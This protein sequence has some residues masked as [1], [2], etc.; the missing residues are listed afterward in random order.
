MEVP[1]G[2]HDYLIGDLNAFDAFDVSRWMS[3]ILMFLGS[4]KK[5]DDNA[6]AAV[7]AFTRA[8]TAMAAQI[9]QLDIHTSEKLCLAAVRRKEAGGVG[10]APIIAAGS[11]V[12]PRM[13]YD[14]IKMPEML[15]LFWHVM[16]HNKL[17][18]FF[19]PPQST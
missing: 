17:P 15:A 13:M 16:A 7:D 8:M 14:D 18:D 19:A 10:W 1:V 5:T 12:P 9:P 4:V 2:G 3:P 6:V 11:S